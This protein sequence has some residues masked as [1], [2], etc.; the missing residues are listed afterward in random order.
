MFNEMYIEKAMNAISNLRAN[1]SYNFAEFDEEDAQ[2]VADSVFYGNC[3]E[4]YGHT[5]SNWNWEM[6][7]LY[8]VKFSEYFDS[9]KKQLVEDPDYSEMLKGMV[10]FY[11]NRIHKFIN[12]AKT[13]DSDDESWASSFLKAMT[14]SEAPKIIRT[15][16]W[17]SAWTWDTSHWLFQFPKSQSILNRLKAKD[18][19]ITIPTGGE[20]INN[21]ELW[22]A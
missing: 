6:M 10:Y 22:Y 2:I 5:I 13:Q 8:G 4:M 21:S 1:I 9:E 18:T 7:S 11:V 19:S 16:Y 20:L 15:L 12:D 14:L 17:D 3:D